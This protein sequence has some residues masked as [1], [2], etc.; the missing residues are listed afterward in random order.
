[1]GGLIS[2]LVVLALL[3]AL[4]ARSVRIIPP[5]RA[6]VVVRL[7]R[8]AGL[9]GPGIAFVVPLIDQVRPVVVTEQRTT[10][11][12]EATTRD[13]VAVVVATT[14]ARQVVDPRLALFTISNYALAVDQLARTVVRSV[15]QEMTLDEQLARRD[16]LGERVK[17]TMQAVTERWGVR[18]NLV[19]VHDIRLQ[20]WSAAPRGKAERRRHALQLLQSEDTLWIAT[21]SA[22]GDAHLVPFS[23]VW[24]GEDI[25]TA[26][27]DESPTVRNVRRTGTAR[28]AVGSFSDV[29]LIEGGVSVS[30]PDEVSQDVRDRL[31]RGPAFGARQSTGLVYLRLTPRRVQTW[32]SMS[33]LA[34]ATIMRSGRWID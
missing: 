6:G 12:T 27:R 8:F 17:E 26:T 19:E 2:I 28:V 10:V 1:M 18:I 11:Q 32:W 22:D 34:D 5:G 21:A 7:G 31:A 15:M 30:S 29:V 13:G 16:R 20:T 33:E 25:M 14:V 9:R 4:V 24:D 3:A 23:F